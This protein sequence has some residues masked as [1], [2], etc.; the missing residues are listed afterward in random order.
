MQMQIVISSD[1]MSPSELKEQLE[2]QPG[3]DSDGVVLEV[4]RPA[5][6]VRPVEPAV[7]V[8]VVGAVGT[9]LVALI[10]GLLQALQRSASKT[11]TI[12]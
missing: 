9:G 3:W 6:A 5:V 1:T 11:I 4:K 2:S 10:S 7:L 12:H 8:A